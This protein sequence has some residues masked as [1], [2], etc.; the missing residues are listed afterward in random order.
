M[1]M[2]CSTAE[3]GVAVIVLNWNRWRDTLR[4]L[5]SV[6]QS[7]YAQYRVIV[8][9]NG[10]RD[11]SVDKIMQWA[12]GAMP[13]T[14]D[15][16]TYRSDNKPV[17]ASVV[18]PRQAAG[19]ALPRSAAACARLFVVQN[20]KNR[21]FARGNNTGIRYAFRTLAARYVMLLNNDTV[22]GPDCLRQLVGAAER[23]TAAGAWQPKMLALA[24]GATIDTAGIALRSDDIFAVAVGHGRPDGEAFSR[25]GDVFGAC[26]GAA[27]YRK[28]MLDR[29]GLFDEDFFAYYEDVD[30]AFRARLQ[31]W[32]ARYVPAAVVYHAHSATLGKQ[33]PMKTRLLER[34]R[35]FCI[36]KNA[37][38]SVMRGFLRRRPGAVRANI[39]HL[40]REKQYRHALAYALG[41]LEAVVRLPGCFVKRL[42]NRR[43]ASVGNEQL[44]KWF[45]P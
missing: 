39:E 22:I 15:F 20:K 24:A 32:G 18:T 33:A 44:M 19:C 17:P 5:E 4:C 29:T 38:R 35:Y 45:S 37:P 16:F 13:V 25:G 9:D 31:G 30:L 7:T 3:P 12:A 40:V 42:R 14:S 28:D 21:G 10:S 2:S 43:A 11:G 8:V 23:D 1:D 41:N 34:N 6:F 26:A 36:V 27:L